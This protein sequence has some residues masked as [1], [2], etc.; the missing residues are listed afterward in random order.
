MK[1]FIVAAVGMGLA[2]TTLRADFTYEQTTKITGGALVGMMKFAAAMSKDAR[3]AMDPIP[4][5]TSV[6]GNR[7]VHKSADSASI[8]DLDKETIT[9]VN[10][11]N[12]TY[13]E[14]TFAQ[15]KQTMEELAQKMQKG[16]KSSSGEQADMQFDVKVNDTGKT[17]TINGSNA[18]EVIMT[19]TMQGTDAKSGAKG[20][21][22]MTTDMWI[23]P[24]ITGYDQMRDFQRRMA[25]KLAWIPGANPMMMSRPDMQRAMAQLYKEGSKLDGMPVY[26]VISMG[27]KV[28]GMPDSAAS[29]ASPQAQASPDSTLPPTSVSGALGAA[30]GGR[31]GMGGFG[32]KKK[33]DAPAESSSNTPS[34]AS[35]NGT[36][37]ASG[38][39]M[40][41][42]MEV[43]SY[44]SAPADAS[45]FE[46]PA[47]FSK[48]EENPMRPN[49]RGK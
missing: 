29:T 34:P 39:L 12:K 30:L 4:A 9:H 26:Q 17:K 41:M 11:A 32:R 37:S 35:G 45:L 14:M 6:K 18:H 10:F 33:Q 2:S 31:L 23:A 47:G 3:K 7:M 43:T 15:M 40:E 49:R 8:I 21:L 44:T 25:E 22:D 38:S 42:T 24:K 1:T 19:F 20:G 46:V 36:S 27:G 16:S 28:E 48:V 13:S 5:T